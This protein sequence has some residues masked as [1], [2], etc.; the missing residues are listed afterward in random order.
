[1]GSGSGGTETG[2]SGLGSGLFGGGKT[3]GPGYGRGSA[4]GSGMGSVTA[5]GGEK[6]RR[7]SDVSIP[8]M[9]PWMPE[10]RGEAT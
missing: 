3:S 8:G 9:Q 1:M 4:G 2:E 6:K 10:Q 7:S 5:D